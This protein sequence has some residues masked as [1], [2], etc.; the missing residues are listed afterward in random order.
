VFLLAEAARRGAAKRSSVCD[1]IILLAVKK[2]F[3]KEQKK[4]R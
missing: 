2:K 3:S 1:K 4:H